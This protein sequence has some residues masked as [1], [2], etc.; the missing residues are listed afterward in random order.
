MS[1]KKFNRRVLITSPVWRLKSEPHKKQKTAI[2][3]SDFSDVKQ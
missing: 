1:S 2:S 3:R